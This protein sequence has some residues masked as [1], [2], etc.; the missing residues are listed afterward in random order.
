MCF[1]RDFDQIRSNYSTR[2][3]KCLKTSCSFV[4]KVIGE[5][6]YYLHFKQKYFGEFVCLR[7]DGADPSDPAGEFSPSG[8]LWSPSLQETAVTLWVTNR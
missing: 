2:Y 4:F 5:F 7:L 3:S 8:I 1:F 6:L